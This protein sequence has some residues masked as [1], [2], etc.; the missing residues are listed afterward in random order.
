MRLIHYY[1]FCLLICFSLPLTAQQVTLNFRDMDINVLIDTVAEITGK[2]FIVDPRVKANV[3]V[4]SNSPMNSE[5]VYQVFL[6]IL[7]VHGYAAVESGKVTKILP[8]SLAKSENTPVVSG[9][10]DIQGDTLITKVISLKH[11]SAAQLIP[12]LRP[13]IP[14]QGHLVAYP[15]NNTIIV[16]DRADNVNRLLHIVERIDTSPQQD[17]D[18]I[19]LQHA[20]AAETARVITS[21]EQ[22]NSAAST[23]AGTPDTTSIIADERTNSLLISG[24]SATRLRIRTLVAHLDTSIE[25]VGNTQVVYLHYA[26]AEE[27]AKVLQ[28]MSDGIIATTTQTGQGQPSTTPVSTN[29]LANTNSNNNNNGNNT[30]QTIKTS[31]QAD[32]ST[33]SLV[34]TAAPSVLLNLQAVIRQ[35]D[36]RR[37]QVLV[38][39]IIAE[40]SAD[41]SNELGVQWFMYGKENGPIGLSNFS[42]AGPSLSS[43]ASAVDSYQ[44]GSSSSLSSVDL[45]GSFLGLGIFNSNTFNI[46]LLVRALSTDTDSNVLSTPSLLTLDNQEAEIVVG[47]NVPFITGQYSNTGSSSSVSNPFQTIQREDVGLKLKVKPQI[48]EGNAVKLDIEQEVSSITRSSVTT[49]DIVTNKRTIKTTVMVEDGNMIVL[50]GLID[51]NLQQTMQKVPGLGDLPLVGALFR[52]QSTQKVRKNLMVFL[53]PVIIRNDE[54]GAMVSGG[55]YAYM[56]T[57]QLEQREK[58]ANNHLISPKEVPVL[59]DMNEFLT[60]LP[61]TAEGTQQVFP[62]H[63]L[64][65]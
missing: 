1:L 23:A 32:P 40:V 16:S 28:G 26:R 12:L 50:G 7:S 57:Q 13:L 22:K 58:E 19:V 37:A 65:Q 39:A 52:S 51:E 63:Q 29:L 45:T 54:K 38:E 3:T 35:L 48:N 21:L 41:I 59:P 33:N 17:V 6:S 4:V 53:R 55:K 64:L 56:R 18:I 10:D 27:L 42:N 9:L 61:G 43:L 34:I 60:I 2:T 24:D 47:Q 20:S 44:N 49:A 11:V 8:D 30:G 25:T 14:Q 46:G 31:I 15:S 5:Q 36:V 62:A